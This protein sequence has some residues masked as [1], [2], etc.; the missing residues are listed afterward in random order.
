MAQC[1]GLSKRTHQRGQ[2]GSSRS[3][4]DRHEEC[5]PASRARLRSLA[6]SPAARTAAAAARRQS[7]RQSRRQS[8]RQP[9]QQLLPAPRRGR[10]QLAASA[11]AIPATHT[12]TTPPPPP[13]PTAS[14]APPASTAAALATVS[15][16]T[17]LLAASSPPPLTLR[18]PSRGQCL[19][20]SRSHRA[21]A[22]LPPT[23]LLPI[24]SPAIPQQLPAS[25]LRQRQR[26]QRVS[27]TVTATFT[28][29]RTG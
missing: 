13:T 7:H 16:T 20:Q 6:A 29:T 19:A 11:L 23:S 18:H 22:L 5:F 25:Q 10:K 26:T 15:P 1:R 24:P 14:P 3:A 17:T 28:S 8:R 21:N 4:M 27:S 9:T 2:L 12:A